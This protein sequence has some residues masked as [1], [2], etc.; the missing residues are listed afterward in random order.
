MKP[1]LVLFDLNPGVFLFCSLVFRVSVGRRP[2]VPGWRSQLGDSG[3]Y[4]GRVVTIMAPPPSHARW[5]STEDAG[6]FTWR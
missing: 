3:G 5:R 6:V 1:K 4:A 2:D